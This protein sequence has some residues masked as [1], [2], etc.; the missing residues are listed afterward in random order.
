MDVP[1]IEAAKGF[2]RGDYVEII[3]D[4]I[5]ITR[6]IRSVEGATITV[7]APLPQSVV[8][9]EVVKVETPL[10]GTTNAWIRAV[11]IEGTILSTLQLNA[12]HMNTVWATNAR[13]YDNELIGTAD[14]R[15]DER[16]V[17]R[18]TPV[19][20]GEIVEVRELEGARAANEWTRIEEE[21][22]EQGRNASDLRLEFDRRSGAVKEAWVRWHPRTMAQ[23][24]F[25]TEDHRHYFLDGTSGHLVFGCRLPPPGASIVARRYRS[26]GGD[27]GNV[28]VGEIS[29]LLGA[30]AGV[31]SVRNVVAADGGAEP[32]SESDFLRFAR[33][34]TRHWGAAI[35]VADYEALAREAT[36]AVIAAK[37]RAATAPNGLPRAGHVTLSIVPKSDDPMPLPSRELRRVVK[38]FILKRT[39]ATVSCDQLHIVDPNYCPVDVVVRF[40]PVNVD[41]AR[42]TKTRIETRLRRFLHPGRGGRA[43]FGWRFGEDV[44]SADIAATVEEIRDV[45]YVIDIQLQSE[46]V[47][48]GEI[49]RVPA[50]AIVA[51]GE[52]TVECQL[53]RE[54][55]CLVL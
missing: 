26:G 28:D 47:P 51:A 29:Q 35:S 43:G 8:G 53:A 16:Y 48:Q 55:P 37:A 39:P 46:G 38:H 17:I 30:A 52:I 10:F 23:L 27:A 31:E 32:A 11:Q 4:E 7:E 33:E 41:D 18:E 6:R 20:P 49:M 2:N 36:T 14:G 54:Q 1:T 34:R 5:R 13:T 22:V 21:L 24:S 3:A 44:Y 19:L 45:D 42:A 12:I 15:S 50:G 25:S 40:T 9:A